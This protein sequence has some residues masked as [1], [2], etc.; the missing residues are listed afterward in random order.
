MHKYKEL[1]AHTN[2]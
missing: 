2:I 1:D